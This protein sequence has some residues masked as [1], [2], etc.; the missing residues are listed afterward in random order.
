[1]TEA[2]TTY[3]V[4]VS[5]TTR[6]PSDVQEWK[7]VA[8]TGNER[9]GGAQYDYV[10]KRGV[11]TETTELLDVIVEALNMRAVVDAVLPPNSPAD[12]R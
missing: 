11:S 2:V 9:D 6:T 4:Q 7:Q 12:V 8:D 1:M 10:T 3:R 5:R